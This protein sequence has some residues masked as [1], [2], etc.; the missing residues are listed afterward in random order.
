[1]DLCRLPASTPVPPTRWKQAPEDVVI[2][3]RDRL[4]RQI[5]CNTAAPTNVTLG[6]R[7][8]GGGTP[9]TPD[10]RALHLAS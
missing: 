4:H 7:G 5:R 9:C 1:M 6:S 8:C 3:L 10:Q 2:V